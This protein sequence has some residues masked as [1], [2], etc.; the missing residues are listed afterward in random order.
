MGISPQT[1]P[2]DEAML[3]DGGGGGGGEDQAGGGGVAVSS[4]PWQSVLGVEGA[5]LSLWMGLMLLGE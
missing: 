2:A 1:A 3:V 5:T 4:A